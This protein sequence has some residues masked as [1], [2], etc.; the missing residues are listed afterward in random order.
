MQDNNIITIR[1]NVRSGKPTIRGLRTTVY[2]I[3]SMLASGMSHDEI[4]ADFPKLTREDIFASLRYAAD[5]E[6]MTTRMPQSA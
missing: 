2:D 5:K 4:L 3:L 1:N 6:Y